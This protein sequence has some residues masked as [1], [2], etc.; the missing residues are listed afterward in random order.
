MKYYV[1]KSLQDYVGKSLQQWYPSVI[2]TTKLISY[3]ILELTENVSE[4]SLARWV[5]EISKLKSQRS[6]GLTRL[7]IRFSALK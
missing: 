5:C 1:G 2:T 7:K 6:S 3:G 4:L